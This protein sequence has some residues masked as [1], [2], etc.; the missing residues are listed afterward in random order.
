MYVC[1]C[2]CVYV[3]MY[4]YMYV[5]WQTARG[6]MQSPIRI[7]NTLFKDMSIVAMGSVIVYYIRAMD[8]V[9]NLFLDM[10]EYCIR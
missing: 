7:S 2:V 1:M 9:F 5:V 6:A 8:I 10:V 4:V 3:C